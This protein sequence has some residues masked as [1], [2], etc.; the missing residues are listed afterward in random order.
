MES[1]DYETLRRDI[2]H[3]LRRLRRDAG[4]SQ[5]ELSLQAGLDRSYVS[6]IERAVVNP[7]LMVLATLASTLNRDVMELLAP[8]AYKL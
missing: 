4:L 1:R 6:R 5:E 8:S 7:S 2:S 3:N